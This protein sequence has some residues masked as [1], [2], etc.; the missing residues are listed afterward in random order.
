[1]CVDTGG[2]LLLFDNRG[3]AELYLLPSYLSLS[4]DEDNKAA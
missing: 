4:Q 1:M 3:C 2:A